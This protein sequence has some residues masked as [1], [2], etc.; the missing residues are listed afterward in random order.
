MDVWKR[1]PHKDTR[2]R[3]K[4]EEGKIK[5]RR[6]ASDV[7]G[8]AQCATRLPRHDEGNCPADDNIPSVDVWRVGGRIKKRPWAGVTL[9]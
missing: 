6:A 3:K 7:T 1:P 2:K 8:T 5:R 4:E 9:P